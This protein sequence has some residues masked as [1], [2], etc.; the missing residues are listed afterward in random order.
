M[1][2]QDLAILYR[3]NPLHM[4]ACREIYTTALQPCTPYESIT[5]VGN[6]G[7]IDKDKHAEA[8]DPS[9]RLAQPYK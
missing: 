1:T 3:Q 4:H 5:C 8:Q 9:V 6:R 7:V 2:S